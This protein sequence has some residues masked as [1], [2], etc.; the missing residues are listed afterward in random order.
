M[1]STHSVFGI[2]EETQPVLLPLTGLCLWTH[3][4]AIPPSIPQK[5]SSSGTGKSL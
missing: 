4:H 1:V 5:A 3:M 2:E